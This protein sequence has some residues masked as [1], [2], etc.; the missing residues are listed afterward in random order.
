MHGLTQPLSHVRG[1][2]AALA[3]LDFTAAGS[4][5]AAVLGQLVPHGDQEQLE[6]QQ[7]AEGQQV[8]ALAGRQ[9]HTTDSCGL[10][11]ASAGQGSGEQQPLVLVPRNS[12][13]QCSNNHTSPVAPALGHAP[14]SCSSPAAAGTQGG[15]L[16]RT[17]STA[18]SSSSSSTTPSTSSTST[19]TS[20]SLVRVAR[21]AAYPLITLLRHVSSVLVA[22]LGSTTAV[23]LGTGLGMLRLGRLK[24]YRVPLAAPLPQL[25]CFASQSAICFCMCIKES[26]GA[27]KMRVQG[28][29]AWQHPASNDAHHHGVQMPTCGHLDDMAAVS[30]IISQMQAHCSSLQTAHLQVHGPLDMHGTQLRTFSQSD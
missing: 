28:S 19:R 11:E 29:K 23:A 21:G 26:F 13:A 20:T 24:P 17:G 3:R 12:A 16:A 7:V 8:E 25:L 14:D 1:A 2:L 18:G 15:G 4:E 9:L 6:G 22:G 27:A 5:A 30:W 10:L